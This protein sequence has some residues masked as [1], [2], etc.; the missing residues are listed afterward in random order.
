MV[1]TSSDCTH[2]PVAPCMVMG[3]VGVDERNEMVAWSWWLRSVCPS[4]HTL[5]RVNG[6]HKEKEMDKLVDQHG[7]HKL[8]GII[9]YRA[10]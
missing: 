8:G 10:R 2:C 3:C 4:I 6:A 9:G 5:V 7:H 1:V